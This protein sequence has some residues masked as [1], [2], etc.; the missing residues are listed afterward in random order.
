MPNTRR[1]SQDTQG[2]Q[3]YPASS[4]NDMP[5]QPFIYA[6]GPP[7]VMHASPAD[8]QY[9]RGSG[10]PSPLPLANP[11]QRSKPTDSGVPPSRPTD[12]GGPPSRNGRD[13]PS[14]RHLLYGPYHLDAR[15]EVRGANTPLTQA[16][17]NSPNRRGQHRV[18]SQQPSHYREHVRSPRA[19]ADWI[20]LGANDFTSRTET[21]IKGVGLESAGTRQDPG[22]GTARIAN[23]E[24][25]ELQTSS[26]RAAFITASV[27]HLFQTTY[28]PTDSLTVAALLLYLRNAMPQNK[29]LDFD[30]EE[31]V[32]ALTTLA[33]RRGE[34]F[35]L[36]GNVLNCVEKRCEGGE[37]VV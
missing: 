7:V 26:G 6:P 28:S 32:Q 37:G 18:P 34:P 14:G 35:V 33:E 15:R 11:W 5:Q 1:H 3:F 8:A 13:T 22:N 19:A 23:Y 25:A 16:S 24:R 20:T 12:P 36:E 4:N 27:H 29:Y 17:P 9:A 21:T 31:V 2:L 10:I 30:T